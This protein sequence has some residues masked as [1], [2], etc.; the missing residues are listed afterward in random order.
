MGPAKR[1]LER[2]LGSELR[3]AVSEGTKAGLIKVRLVCCHA[4][5]HRELST[6]TL[7]HAAQ[8]GD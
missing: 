6:P 7:C 3:V 8:S 2:P 1:S 5:S 4:R